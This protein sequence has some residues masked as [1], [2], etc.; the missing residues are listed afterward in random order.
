[1]PKRPSAPKIELA[2]TGEPAQKKTFIQWVNAIIPFGPEH[3]RLPILAVLVT[4]LLL[5]LMFGVI[6]LL[7]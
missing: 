4:M 5:G 3:L 6:T 1:V 2:K 7:K